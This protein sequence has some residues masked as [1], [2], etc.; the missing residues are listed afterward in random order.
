MTEP[1]V[2]EE[3]WTNMGAFSCESN[4]SRRNEHTPDQPNLGDTF[5]TFILPELPFRLERFSELLVNAVALAL[6]CLG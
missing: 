5:Y 1:V 3:N 4:I 6:D 2:L